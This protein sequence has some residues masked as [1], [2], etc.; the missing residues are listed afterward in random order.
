MSSVIQVLSNTKILNKY[1]LKNCYLSDTERVDSKAGGY[2]AHAL[3]KLLKIM[4]FK[5]SQIEPAEFFKSLKEYL[6]S[7]A[8]TYSDRFTSR[9]QE[10]VHE[11]L[12]FLLDELAENLRH[13]P[14]INLPQG[15]P[16]LGFVKCSLFG[17]IKALV[18]VSYL[19]QV[20]LI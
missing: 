20:C 6:R 4:W 9:R 2:L 8:Q 14:I 19:I 10:D 12:S 7:N 5:N 11:F 17:V 1:F 18:N 3:A 16:G 13:E 15:K